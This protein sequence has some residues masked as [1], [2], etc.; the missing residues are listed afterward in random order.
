M[1]PF[2]GETYE[3]FYSTFTRK[4]SI[5]FIFTEDFISSCCFSLRFSL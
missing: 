1:P 3:L 2:F 4:D 5:M